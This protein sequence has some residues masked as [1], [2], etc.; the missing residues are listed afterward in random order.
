MGQFGFLTSKITHAAVDMQFHRRLYRDNMRKPTENV[1]SVQKQ[2]AIAFGGHIQVQLLIP[3][4]FRLSFQTPDSRIDPVTDGSAQ[5]IQD[6]VID[7]GSSGG[8]RQL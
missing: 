7:I 2:G 4:N 6:Q 5:H 8:K 1:S 3:E